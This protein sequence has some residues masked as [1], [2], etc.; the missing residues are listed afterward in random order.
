MRRRALLLGLPALAGCGF[1]LK[2]AAQ[3]NF[4]RIALTGFAPRS[5]LADELRGVLA[6][7]ITVVPTPD[8]AEVVL[9]ALVDQRSRKVVAFTAS[10]QVRDIQLRMLFRYSARTPADRELIAPAEI[11]MNRDLSFVE[12]K[13]LGK[14]Q[15]EQALFREMQS[16]IVLQVM[17]RLSTIRL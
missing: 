16:D 10:G 11:D 1:E 13:T 8:Q 15:E 3:L 14:E 9:Q 6:R 4:Q 17:L 7:S 2:R 12:A 5:P